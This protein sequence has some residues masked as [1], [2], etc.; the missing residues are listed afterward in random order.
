MASDRIV[1]TLQNV[2]FY[3]DLNNNIFQLLLINL[4]QW[5]NL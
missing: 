5:N 4:F 2:L 1:F 3:N